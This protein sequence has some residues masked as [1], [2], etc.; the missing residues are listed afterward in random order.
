MDQAF[1]TGSM[2]RTFKARIYPTGSSEGIAVDLDLDGDVL[3]ASD[4]VSTASWP[5][6]ALRLNL[7]GCA[8]DRV[9]VHCPSGDTLISTDMKILGALADCPKLKNQVD[10]TRG[11]HTAATFRRRF[12]TAGVLMLWWGLPLMILGTVFIAIVVGICL[13][14]IDPDS[15]DSKAPA[16]SAEQQQQPPQ[17]AAVPAE[18]SNQAPREND[19]E[20]Q[21][22]DAA[23][24]EHIEKNFHPPSR[25]KSLKAVTR[26]TIK[27]DGKIANFSMVQSSGN[28]AFDLAAKNAVMKHQ[29]LPVPPDPT[30]QMEF[31][32][33]F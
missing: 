4:G 22:Y 18:S 1:R 5:M 28:K 7:G 30:R 15:T 31:E 26:F 17:E 14:I 27:P 11:K 8:E 16:A 20:S 25:M 2:N 6:T 33:E 29:P 19:A 12:S 21:A 9:V 23:V 13:R 32:Y 10:S 3:V 24:V